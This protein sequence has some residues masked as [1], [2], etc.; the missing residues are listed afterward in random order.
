MQESKT[1]TDISVVI[2]ARNAA[3]TISETLRSVLD[4]DRLAE[5][6]VVDDGSTDA[7]VAVVTAICD[8]RIRVI[9]GPCTGIANAL[10]AGFWAA[11]SCYVARCDADD[12][13][14]P[15]RLR[16]QADWLDGNPCYIAVSGGFLS[17][18]RKGNRL[19]ELASHGQARD[20]TNVLK[21]GQAVTH[22]CTWLMR[23]EAVLASGGARS[24]FETAEDIDL[25]V[26]LA[27]QG[28]VWHVP[29]PVYGYRLHEA[30]ITHSRKAAQLA[31]YD[32]AVR[33]FAAE[34]RATGTDALDRDDPPPLSDFQ[35]IA[36]ARN[37]AKDQIIGHLT[38]QA[39]ADFRQGRRGEGIKNIVRA[40]ARQ[41]F[42]GKLWKSLLLMLTRSLSGQGE[43]KG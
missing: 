34:R 31:F 35:T 24:W 33:S 2:P 6:I 27:F 21:D 40:L 37:H 7:T 20:V 13:Y 1:L 9:P 23:R 28:R 19:A 8:P 5:L 26:R 3:A 25:Q 29:R 12:L 15:G 42:K 36:G 18:D 39:W 11:T 43:P 32:Q 4:Q 17:L 10:N 41:P 22:L 30:S 14:L 38:S 16:K